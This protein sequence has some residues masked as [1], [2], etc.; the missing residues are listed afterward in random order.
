MV[1]DL[2]KLPILNP[3]CKAKS[4]AA[5]V[6]AFRLSSLNKKKMGGAVNKLSQV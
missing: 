4:Q 2:I 1:S 5:E 6:A 3:A